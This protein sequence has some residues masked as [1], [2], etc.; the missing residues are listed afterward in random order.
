MSHELRFLLLQI[1]NRDDAMREHEVQCFMRTLPATREQIQ[2]FDLLTACPT[3][4]ELEQIDIV[5]LGGSG[6]YSATSNEP[7]IENAME[8]MRELHELKQ[9][10]FASCWGF[11]AMARALGG[12]VVKDL[13]RAEVG[14][15][16]L[17]LTEAGL[18]DPVFAP[19]GEVFPGQ[20]GHEDIVDELPPNAV[21]LASSER[22]RNQAYRLRDAPIYCTQFHPELQRD[23]LMQ[24]IEVYPEYIERIAGLP[25]ERFPE[26]T[27]ES[28]GTA[29]LL[30][31]FV[32]WV[33]E[34]PGW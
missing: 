21:L 2:V 15:H 32:S 24:R 12:K 5:L 29:K 7:W 11:Q 8:A 18:D 17:R 6:H 25:P 31:R 13:S 23:D 22:V 27:S 34:Q 33:R 16:E 1:R 19:L 30:P 4:R 10:T 14:T 9:P 20:M 3:P 28:P 26:L